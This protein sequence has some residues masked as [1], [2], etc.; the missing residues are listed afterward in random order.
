MQNTMPSFKRI[1]NNSN[2]ATWNIDASERIT[3][4]KSTIS[5]S[6]DTIRNIYAG[7]VIPPHS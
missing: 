7:N 2:Y 1:A 5:N 6:C 3:I 4:F